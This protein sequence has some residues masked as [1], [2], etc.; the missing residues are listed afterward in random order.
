MSTIAIEIPEA[1]ATKSV[2]LRPDL[3]GTLMTPEE[4]DAVADAEEGY[5]YELIHG[6]LVVTPP[7]L[8][9][10]RGPNEELGFWLR[11]YRHQHPRDS[12]LD[13]TLL[14]H[15]V[16]GT[17]DRRRA[18]RVIWAGLGR[19]PNPRRDLPTI[20]VEFASAGKGERHRDRLEKR[21]EYLELGIA[22]YWIID[23]F[24]HTQSICRAQS[25]YQVIPRDAVYATPLLPGFELPIARLLEFADRRHAGKTD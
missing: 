13:E 8:E 3:A 19:M 9:E 20:V 11:L 23:R 1:T 24:R 25:E 6:I 22:E 15:H 2:V 18:D 7:P 5:V 14:E 17:V 21:A 10:E 4:F 16:R 12:A